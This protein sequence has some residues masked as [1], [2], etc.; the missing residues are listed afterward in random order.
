MLRVSE[1]CSA[2]AS[3]RRL[4]LPTS[5]PDQREARGAAAATPARAPGQWPK[6]TKTNSL[7]LSENGYLVP[8]R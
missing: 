4:S 7:C 5:F 8:K 1:A 2:A 3:A 6:E